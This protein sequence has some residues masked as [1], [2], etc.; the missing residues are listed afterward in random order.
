VQRPARLYADHLVAA[1]GV[2]AGFGLG[3][4]L[5]DHVGGAHRL[6]AIDAARHHHRVGGLDRGAGKPQAGRRGW[7]AVGDLEQHVEAAVAGI[8]A[9]GDRLHLAGVGGIELQRAQVAVEGDG[10]VGG[11]AE[12]VA[13]LQRASDLLLDFLAGQRAREARHRDFL[14]VAGVDA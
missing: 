1:H 14:Q 5:D 8:V 4:A 13:P 10:E 11:V 9:G 2:L 12:P 3:A 6:A 7:G